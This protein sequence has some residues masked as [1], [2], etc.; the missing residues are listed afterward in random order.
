MRRS[1]LTDRSGTS[2][3][4]SR[5]CTTA[6]CPRAA[7]RPRPGRPSC[8][9][10]LHPSRIRF[11]QGKRPDR[12]AACELRHEACPLL[13]GAELD[14]RQARRARVH[15]D[16]DPHAG[17]GPREL[18]QHEDVRD[19]VRAC[20]AERLRDADA[21]QAELTELREELTREVVLPVPLRGVRS[22]LGLRHVAGERLDLALLV[23]EREVH[24]RSLE[25]CPTEV[26]HRGA[27]DRCPTS[28]GHLQ[29]VPHAAQPPPDGSREP[30]G[31]QEPAQPPRR[32]L[33]AEHG[34]RGGAAVAVADPGS[35]ERG[36]ARQPS[37]VSS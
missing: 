21:H 11:R 13:V 22:D 24:V 20:A 9:V 37:P 18:F 26:G 31:R 25:R 28:V 30:V 29:S 27:G 19:E 23:G 6:S 33:G 35:T 8:A 5:S 32:E 2:R 10:S 7:S 15:G 16:G 12:L 34:R 3:R 1:T 14:D 17:V 36:A 4:G